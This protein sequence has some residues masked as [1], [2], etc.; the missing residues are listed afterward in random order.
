[1]RDP[2]MDERLEMDRLLD[3]I[4]A[5]GID[6]LSADERRFLDEAAKRRRGELH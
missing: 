3:K 6:A 5:A 1:M 2:V 4:S